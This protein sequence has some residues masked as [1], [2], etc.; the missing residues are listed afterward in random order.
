MCFG[1]RDYAA[2]PRDLHCSY[3]SFV[4]D[5][6]PLTDSLTVAKQSKASG[7]RPLMILLRGKTPQVDKVLEWLVSPGAVQ[8]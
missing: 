3:K 2:V 7:A 6:L 5:N 4:D 1:Q 8:R